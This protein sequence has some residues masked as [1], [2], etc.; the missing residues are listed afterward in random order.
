MPSSHISSAA[1]V[2]PQVLIELLVRHRRMWIVPMV[3]VAVLAGLYTLVMPRHWK[4]TQGMLI[5]PEAAGLGTDRLG[6]FS[7][8]SEMKT[9]Q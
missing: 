3:A 9:I 1:G 8:L 4:A 7:D 2:T 6:K 5:R